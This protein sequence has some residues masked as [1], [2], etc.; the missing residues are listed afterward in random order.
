MED[1]DLA[2]LLAAALLPCIINKNCEMMNA[3]YLFFHTSGI[4]MTISTVIGRGTI[5]Q[6]A[7]VSTS[8]LPPPSSPAL[9]HLHN[10]I[11]V[12]QGSLSVGDSPLPRIDYLIT[13]RTFLEPQLVS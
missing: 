13:Q 9:Q 7:P 6:I 12:L 1:R 10:R 4:A 3:G 5:D 11:R 2:A 8:L